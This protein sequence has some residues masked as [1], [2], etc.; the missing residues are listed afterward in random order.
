VAHIDGAIVVTKDDGHAYAN[1]ED[2]D[3]EEEEKEEKGR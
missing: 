2:A 1:K 3:E